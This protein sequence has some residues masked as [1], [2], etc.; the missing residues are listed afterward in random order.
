MNRQLVLDR[1]SNCLLL[2]SLLFEIHGFNA[3]SNNRLLDS[4]LGNGGDNLRS[5]KYVRDLAALLIDFTKR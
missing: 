4:I 5:L 1:L 2:A 3:M